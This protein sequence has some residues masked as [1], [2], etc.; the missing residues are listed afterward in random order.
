MEQMLAVP[1]LQNLNCYVVSY[2]DVKRND[3]KDSFY[4]EVERVSGQF[5][6]TT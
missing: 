3:V 6:G 4:E 5:L 1:K 2:K